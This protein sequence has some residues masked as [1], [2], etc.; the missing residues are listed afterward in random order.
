MKNLFIYL[1]KT[2]LILGLFTAVN[3]CSSPEEAHD[4]EEQHEESENGVEL[5]KAQYNQAEI[6][7]GSVKQLMMGTELNV[8]GKIDLPPQSNISI[9]MPYGG[10][11]KYTEMLPGTKVRKGQLLAII[12]NPDFIEFQ[13]EYL[14]NIANRSFLKA[15]YERQEKLFSE[16]IAAGKN[17]Q[18]AKS[19]YLANEAGIMALEKR[20]ELIGLKPSEVREGKIS[21]EVNLYSPV[22]GAVREVYANVGKFV[23]PKDVIMNITNSED[24]HVELTVYE[25]DI[26]K[27]KTGQRIR[28]TIANSLEWREAE[29]FL[30]GSGVREDRSV[31]VHGHLKVHEQDLLPGMYVNARVETDRQQVW[32]VPE[33][34]IVRFS[35]K[36]YVFSYNGLKQENGQDLHDFVMLEIEKG[37][38]EDGNTQI[39][40]MDTNISIDKIEIVE[41]GAFTLLA[42]AKNMESEGGHHH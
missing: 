29:V 13:Q 9:N 30:V 14:E 17:F 23:A 40:L 18:Q 5:S 12:E 38:T 39:S 35:G 25:N 27:V 20:L 16:N 15:E 22:N 37:I 8:N 19:K 21:A 7:L 2:V 4:D 28:F 24:L 32:A 1:F 6:Q 31:N 42:K 41:K 36:H 10:F 33:E 34:A 3:S 11:V 26:P